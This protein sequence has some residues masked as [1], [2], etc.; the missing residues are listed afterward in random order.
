MTKTFRSLI[1]CLA[2]ILSVLNFEF[3][4]FVF[5]WD[6][7]FDAWNFHDFHQ[8]SNFV[9]I[10]LPVLHPMP[11]APCSM[12][13]RRLHR[14]SNSEH[15]VSNNQHRASCNECPVSRIQSPG[16][17]YQE[18]ETSDQLPVTPAPPH[19]TPSLWPYPMSHPLAAEARIQIRHTG[20]F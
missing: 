7:W 20:V 3:R 14:T 15:Q 9:E 5:V 12:L 2:V 13:C 6:L 8:A 1:R 19:T 4:S 16:H 10:L 17:R 18:P 11:F